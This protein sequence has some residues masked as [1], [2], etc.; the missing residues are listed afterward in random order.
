[1][2][3]AIVKH[4][5]ASIVEDLTGRIANGDAAVGS[6]LPTELELCEQYGVARYTVRRALAHLQELGLISRRKN[7]GS[8]VLASR[9]TTGFTQSLASV[10]DL[11]QFGARH[12]RVVREIAHV[13]LDAK[14]A[15]LLECPVG[16]PCLRISSLRM[17][18]GKARPIGWTDV[19]IDPA[20]EDVGKLARQQPEVLVSTLI[21]SRH[22][23]RIARIR[24]DIRASAIPQRLAAE[25]GAAEGSPALQ[26]VR[27]YFDLAG[28]LFEITVTMHPAERFTFS[29]DLNR[30]REAGTMAAGN[31]T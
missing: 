17:D 25:L 2:P 9:P 26:I 29:M 11:T 14:Q 8:R 16:T 31:G 13:V 15:A 4:T 5:L 24:Q 3:R 21:E 30:S 10:E 18:G 23:R 7:V 20:Y 27:R 28:R 12:V 22:G 1:M 19:Y 6:L